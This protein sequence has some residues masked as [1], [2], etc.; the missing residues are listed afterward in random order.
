MRDH[1]DHLLI[2]FPLRFEHLIGQ[3]LN[4]IEGVGIAVFH[5]RGTGTFINAG[6]SE[7][8]GATAKQG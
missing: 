5:K 4:Q 3:A 6:I 1:A 8:D 2:G 7:T